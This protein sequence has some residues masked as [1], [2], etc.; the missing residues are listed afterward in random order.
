MWIKSCHT[1]PAANALARCRS[2]S[3]A[4]TPGNARANAGR[5]TNPNGLTLG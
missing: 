5:D 3:S 2:D 4:D 1:Q